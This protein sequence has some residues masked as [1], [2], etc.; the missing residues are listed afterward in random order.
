MLRV[1]DYISIDKE[2]LGGNPVFKGT[3]VPVES[4]FQHLEK[5]V[6]L[7]QFLLDFPSVSKDQAIA[8]IEMAGKLMTSKDIE[9]IYETAA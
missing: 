2:I 3:R 6:S 8:T 7:D 4:L 9:K 5:G 1:R